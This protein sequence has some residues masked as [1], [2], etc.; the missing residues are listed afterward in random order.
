MKLRWLVV[1]LALATPLYAQSDVEALLEKAE[2]A[3]KKEQPAVQAKPP[4]VKPRPRKKTKKTDKPT[5]ADAPK[6]L[7][8]TEDPKLASL[9]SLSNS[10]ELSEDTGRLL[11]SFSYVYQRASEYSLEKDDDQFLVPTG[12]DLHGIAI[13]YFPFEM[14]KG[15]EWRLTSAFGLSYLSPNLRVRRSGLINEYRDY[16]HRIVNVD[17]GLQSSWR[18][19]DS[20]ELVSGLSGSVASLMQDGKEENDTIFNAT[21]GLG[22]YLAAYRRLTN[23]LRAGLVGGYRNQR[24]GRKKGP[25]HGWSVSVA[26]GYLGQGG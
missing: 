13:G 19:T 16:Q 5:Q 3:M 20:S 18:L 4:V 15:P 2:S 26:I 1:T 7:K 6:D 8:F 24:I 21:A 14:A 11:W 10:Q 12:Q 25:L 23:Q 9:M 17:M 22:A